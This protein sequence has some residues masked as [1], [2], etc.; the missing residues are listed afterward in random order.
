MVLQEWLAFYSAIV[1]V[2]VVVV[3]AVFEKREV[4]TPRDTALAC[5]LER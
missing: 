5:R 1:V 4:S 2:V 3:V